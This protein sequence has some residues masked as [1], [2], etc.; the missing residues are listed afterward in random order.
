MNSKEWS[1]FGYSFLVGSDG[2]V[3][4]G[5]GL[6]VAGVHTKGYNSRSY[7]VSF[8]GNFSNKSP[9]PAAIQAAKDLIEVR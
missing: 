6:N 5:R 2:R 1:D 8:I 7:A 9:T 3:Y 4:E